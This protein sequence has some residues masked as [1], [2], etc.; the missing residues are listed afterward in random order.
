MLSPELSW[1]QRWRDGEAA[2]GR[3]CPS[4]VVTP[5]MCSF[6]G[7]EGAAWAGFKDED[8]LGWS[9]GGKFEA[10]SAFLLGWGRLFMVPNQGIVCP[11]PPHSPGGN[12]Q[13][14]FPRC[15]IHEAWAQPTLSWSQGFG[16]W[17]L[18]CTPSWW[19][20]WDRDLPC[21]P[22]LSTC[23]QEKNTFLL[24]WGANAAECPWC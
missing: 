23:T 2:L 3:G 1:W 12:R 17:A 15:C 4:H 20:M 10:T 6:P 16:C 24:F 13:P 9:C 7:Q 22:A 21:H 14:F 19:R 5:L 11:P 8:G 18:L